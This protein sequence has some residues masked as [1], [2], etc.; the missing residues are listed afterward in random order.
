MNIK[1]QGEYSEVMFRGENSSRAAELV[2]S[3][4]VK[5]FSDAI[6]ATLPEGRYSIA[7]LGSS[8]GEFFKNL[9]NSETLT[10]FTFDTIAVDVNEDD[11]SANSAES[12][13]VSD[14]QSLSLADKSVDIILARYA[15][16]WNNLEGQRKIL[17][18]IKRVTKGIAIIQHQ[19]ANSE[20][21]EGLQDA[22]LQLFSGIIPTLKRDA[23]Y[24]S[25]AEQLEEIMKELNISFERIQNRD[26]DGLSSIFIDKYDLSE[27]DAQTTVDCL[28][29]S[30]YVTQ[31]A[32][33]LR[34]N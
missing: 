13:I 1:E 33:I 28:K 19:G 9:L 17:E 34:F 14:L 2:Y 29:G 30:D 5:L 6:I 4:S 8:K 27:E 32:W 20:N 26:V 25:S 11:I 23:F 16:A 3:E 22:S 7:D 12:R 24:F 21:P 15:L 18:E 10:N 31:T